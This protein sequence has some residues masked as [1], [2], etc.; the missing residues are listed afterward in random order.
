MSLSGVQRQ[1]FYNFASSAPVIRSVLPSL[2]S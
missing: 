2:D 1:D